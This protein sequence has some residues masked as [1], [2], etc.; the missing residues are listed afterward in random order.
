METHDFLTDEIKDSPKIKRWKNFFQLLVALYI[1][2]IFLL[3]YIFLLSFMGDPRQ[4]V[5]IV[6]YS[7]KKLTV[8]LLY[9]NG[10]IEEE[11]LEAGGHSTDGSISGLELIQVSSE[12]KV[13]SVLKF[14]YGCTVN[15]GMYYI[16]IPHEREWGAE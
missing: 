1:S 14:D 2:F 11:V 13:V 9:S 15:R 5:D 6:N 7:S 10:S 4:G 8:D 12:N 3:I 16:V